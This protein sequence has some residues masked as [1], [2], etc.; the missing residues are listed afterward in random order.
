[1]KPTCMDRFA[2]FFEAVKM[3]RPDADIAIV[4]GGCAGLSLARRLATSP[5]EDSVVV[6]EPRETYTDDRSWCFWA[7]LTHA[8]SHL[9]AH[10]WPRW[11]FSTQSGGS[12]THERA[13]LCYQY[14]RS[15]DFYDDAR[16]QIGRHAGVHLETGTRVQSVSKLANQYRI[17]TDQGALSANAVIDTRP[18]PPDSPGLL[19]QCFLGAEVT[20]PRMRPED[21]EI[22]GLMEAMA[23]DA[24]GFNFLYV[25]PLAPGRSLI[26]VTRFAKCRIDPKAL[27]DQLTAEIGRLHGSETE[28]IR[29]EAGV[30]PMG[31]THSVPQPAGPQ[32]VF[33][34]LPGGALRPAS[35]Y[36]FQRIQ[37]WADKCA[38]SIA[39]GH[40]IIGHPP[41]PKIRA[42]MDR[43]FLHA[44]RA[45]PERGADFFMAMAKRL[46]P[47]AFVRFMSDAA[48][49]GDKMNVVTALPP[50]P[51]LKAAWAT[52]RAREVAA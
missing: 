49:V 14:V 38:A 34:G 35:G 30:L 5:V 20:H 41:E 25:L 13:G 26:E 2:P 44:L 10:A 7:G 31:L 50:V 21:A 33:A 17:E 1:M 3:V 12:A 40:G 36:A 16:E 42:L 46:S 32:H 4:G 52:L 23:S 11:R 24:D 22:A 45:H 8:N 43:I 28:V 37:T 29:T 48:T 39:S 27:N 47:D 18:L 9:V 6:L 51:F 19:Y 15:L